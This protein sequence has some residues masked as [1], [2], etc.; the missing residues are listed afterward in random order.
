ME[1]KIVYFD[2]VGPENTEEALRIAKQRADELGIKTI[3]VSSTR[4]D[5]AARA[6]E[7]FKGIRVVAVGHAVGW[8]EPDLQEFTRQTGK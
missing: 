6:V 1:G 7:V 3:L 5:T 2:K 4:G 8:K